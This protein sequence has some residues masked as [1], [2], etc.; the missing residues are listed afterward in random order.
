M[1]KS[2][3]RQM[4][5]EMLKEELKTMSHKYTRIKESAETRDNHFTKQIVYNGDADAAAERERFPLQ[6][7]TTKEMMADLQSD[8]GY[9]GY[10]IV[11]IKDGNTVARRLVK[12]DKDNKIVDEAPNVDLEDSRAISNYIQKSLQENIGRCTRCGAKA[13]FQSNAFGEKLCIDSCWDDFI[14]EERGLVDAY[15]MV[16]NGELFLLD[17]ADPYAKEEELT[18]AWNK[19]RKDLIYTEEECAAIEAK[20]EKEV[21]DYL[22][23]EG[24]L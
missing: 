3:L 2:E 19:Y 9:Q 16:A 10:R 23:G 17:V 13:E 6:V 5:R 11:L 15:E 7:N 22:F 4:I 8:A 12:L 24:A 1:T 14:N 18:N 21:T 20:F